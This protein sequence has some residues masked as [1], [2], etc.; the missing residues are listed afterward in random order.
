MRRSIPVALATLLLPAAAFA[1]AQGELRAQW[2]GVWALTRTAMFSECTDHFT[3]NAVAGEAVSG[4]AIRFAAGEPVQVNGVDW[5]MTGL[6]VRI[7]L[8]EPFRVEWRDGPYTLYEQRRCRVELKFP[9]EARPN[10][11][12]AS[13]AI[14]RVLERLA[15]ADIASS[16]AWNHREVEAY[17]A[18]YARV[19]TEH[20][21]WRAAQ[22]NAAVQRKLDQ[23]LDDASH[24]VEWSQGDADYAADFTAG[25]YE[26]RSEEFSSCESALDASFYVHGSG[27]ASKRGWEDGQRLAWAVHLASALRGCFVTPPL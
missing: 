9:R 17:P 23:A 6:K 20:E 24:V 14:A 3:D 12:A 4:K 7:E 11:A 16:P 8:R 15:E 21:T 13:A 22:T 10:A 18:D 2:Q 1:D 25:L 26:R 5:T 19:R 27:K